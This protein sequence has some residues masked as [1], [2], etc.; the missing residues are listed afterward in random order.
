[1]KKDN[2]AIIVPALYGGGAER[3]VATLSKELIKYNNIYIIIYRDTERKYSYSGNIININSY[4]SNNLFGKV[5]NTVYRIKKIRKI[6][7][8]YKINKTFSFLDNP[9]I[10]NIL[11][12][13]ND[14]IVIS[15]RNHKSEEINSSKQK[16]QKKMMKIIYN[17]ADKIVAISEGV[18]DDLIN[19]F[20]I[21]KS[22]IKVIYNPLDIKYINELKIKEINK[23]F[24]K[25]FDNYTIITSGRL[26]KQKG[27]W[28]L[29][30]AFKEVLTRF[31]NTNL[32]I[33]GKGELE[34]ELKKLSKNLKIDKNVYFL[35]MQENPF[36]YIHKSDLF[37]FPSNFEGFGNV[38]LESMVCDVPIICTDCK[39][40]PKEILN[41]KNINKEISEI[42]LCD[43][44]ILVPKCNGEL[45]IMDNKINES[46]KKLAQAILEVMENKAL[47]KEYIDKSKYR[48]N[49]FRLENISKE[50]NKL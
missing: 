9:N 7:K 45:L 11:T 20:N 6:K 34:E 43:Y 2:I 32:V 30:K 44:G 16:M 38:I 47:A 4:E 25:I 10:I 46:E 37:V 33:L 18:K 42:S 50:W 36:K 8:D 14:K 5:F 26:T 27:Q 39:S 12:K 49:D 31:P 15:I 41:P 17:K 28:H 48:I 1:M 21:K 29:I 40:G 19:N 22:K 13:V 23:E 3:V 35:G 24:E